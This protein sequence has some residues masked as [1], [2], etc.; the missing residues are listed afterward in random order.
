MAQTRNL[1][2]SYG[3]WSD[4]GWCWMNIHFDFSLRHTVCGCDD[5]VL[6][7]VTES[8]KHHP[9]HSAH[10]CLT[11]DS[12]WWCLISLPRVATEQIIKPTTYVRVSDLFWIQ[13]HMEIIDPCTKI[14]VRH[15]C[16]WLKFFIGIRIS[17]AAHNKLCIYYPC[18]DINIP[19]DGCQDIR[20]QSHW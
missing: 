7:E 12:G 18:V 4:K 20:Y 10:V 9:H 15:I 19:Q 11:C 8:S 5:P 1:I 17:N 14:S 16:S 2:N 3:I 6:Y 13:S